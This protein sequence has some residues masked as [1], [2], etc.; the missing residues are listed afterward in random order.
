MLMACA[1]FIL[2]HKVSHSQTTSIDSLKKQLNITKKNDEKFE[3]L[4]QLYKEL[5][6][7]HKEEAA[8][9]ADQ[10]KRLALEMG[11]EVKEAR[12]MKETSK[13]YMVRHQFEKFD[14][15][16]LLVAKIFKKYGEDKLYGNCIN[17]LGAS[18]YYRGNFVEA[19]EY[20]RQALEFYSE[21]DEFSWSTKLNIVSIMQNQGRYS[22]SLKML[23]PLT[24]RFYESGD[25]YNYANCM[26]LMANVYNNQGNN[27]KAK[28]YN[29]KY[30]EQCNEIGFKP[31]IAGGYNNLAI[32]Y[33]KEG[34]Y[35]KSLENC[36]YAKEVF[37]E[38]P[39]N[40]HL[41]NVLILMG[42]VYKDLNKLDK[43]WEINN[44]ALK[45]AKKNDF[46]KIITEVYNNNSNLYLLEGNFEKAKSEAFKSYHLARE[47]NNF[48][49]IRDASF[50]IYNSYKKLGDNINALKYYEKHIQYK[51]SVQN[52]QNSREVKALKRNFEILTKDYENEK[53][54]NENQLNQLEIKEQKTKTLV[55]IIILF[56][57]I[58][59][60]AVMLVLNNK[61]KSKNKLILYQKDE[62]EKA[63]SLKDNM[64]AIIAHDL[65]GPVGNVSTLLD[66]LEYES[67]SEDKESY[68]QILD[69]VKKAASSTFSLLENLLN[70][71][72]QQ[73]NEI[74]YEPKHQNLGGVINNVIDLKLPAA[75]NKEIKIKATIN[76]EIECAFDYQ[77]IDLVIRNLVD[78]AIKFTPVGGEVNVISNVTG[79]QVEISVKDSGIGISEEVKQKLFNKYEYYTTK[80]T[81]N[82]RGSGLGLKLC[83]DFIEYHSGQIWV[84]SAE[85]KGSAFKFTLPLS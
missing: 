21:D 43:A 28:E 25:Q 47:T 79:K 1:M 26:V 80:G 24:E 59:I 38:L 5:I 49:M 3:I 56:A 35:E 67:V 45:I 34:N 57:V 2:V 37:E 50:N 73:K 81:K 8:I 53:L 78:N 41:T 31:G 6:K 71:A 18:H 48:K 39:D 55:V 29:L 22:E 32:I 15:V 51:D 10:A 7:T 65:R 16:N 13:Q 14:S 61:L 12:I 83:Y 46:K 63:N 60:A 30:V 85:G 69:T 72:R 62:L 19:E 11:D 36:I 82:E 44:K 76:K 9:Y 4:F 27:E 33:Y 52:E 42:N 77:M 84:E 23:L 64:F 75:Q 74:K 17:N 70:W 20:F 54:K 40:Y 66:F 68:D 58:V